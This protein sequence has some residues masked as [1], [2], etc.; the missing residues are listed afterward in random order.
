MF[1]CILFFIYWRWE[2]HFVALASQDLYIVPTALKFT[3]F[4]LPLP[5]CLYGGRRP[6]LSLIFQK[7]LAPVVL[8]WFL[9]T[10]PVAC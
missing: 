9:T 7:T 1:K 8:Q 2:S 6:L 5:L 4:C 10:V 3:E